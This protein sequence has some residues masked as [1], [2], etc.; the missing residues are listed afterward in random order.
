MANFPQA[1]TPTTSEC[2]WADTAIKDNRALYRERHKI[3]HNLRVMRLLRTKSVAPGPMQKYLAEGIKVPIGYRLVQSIVGRMNAERPI[4]ERIPRRPREKDD[5]MMLANSADPM[6]Q[7]FEQLAHR[8][9]LLHL[10]DQLVGDGFGVVKMRRIPWQGYPIQQEGQSDKDYNKAV[11]EFVVNAGDQPM[12]A[13]LVDPLNFMPSREEW[14]A[15]FVIEQ[16]KRNVSSFLR[17]NRLTLGVNNRLLKIPDGEPYPELE[18]PSGMRPQDEIVEIWTPES[19]FIRIGTSGKSYLKFPND[20]T[21]DGLLPY[22]WGSG[23]S[24]SLR[25]PAADAMSVLFPIAAL[26][27]WVNLMLTTMAAWS[28]IGGTPILYTSRQAVANAPIVSQ[29]GLA[30]IPLGKRIDL[31]TGG[32]IGFVSPPS[33]GREVVEFVRLLLDFVDRAGLAPMTEGLIGTRTPGLTFSS[34]MEAALSKLKP[35][36]SNA[37]GILAQW[38]KIC[39]KI[40]EDIDAPIYVNGMGF[41]KGRGGSGRETQLGRY[42]IDPRHIDG[43]YDIHAKLKMSSLQDLITQGMHGAFMKAHGL[44]A[45][46]RSMRFA[47]VDDPSSERREINR[48][49]ARS[50]P[51]VFMH[52]LQEAIKEDPNLQKL[53]TDLEAQG[54][55]M[56]TLLTNAAFGG[57]QVETDVLGDLGGEGGGTY[58]GAP[59]PRGG[60]APQAGG[61]PAGMPSRPR[62]PRKNKSPRG[63]RR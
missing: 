60:A 15:A 43:Y 63:Q 6:L 30:E 23:E 34:A 9:L 48:D 56:A 1:E 32:Q 10:Y 35:L 55:D 14:D 22:A 39:W 41:R 17:Q 45:E 50:L 49:K 58:G 53:A 2:A 8:P 18:L 62:G 25:D 31:G 28:I 36:L 12:R 47:G 44:W 54:V 37:E 51:I 27:P 61:S 52:S 57:G 33:V 24:T 59:Q 46:D 42:V 40:V 3:M 7:T 4:F 19:V 20:V 11:A 29:I 13:Q 26:E 16:G 38:V 5:A 21:G